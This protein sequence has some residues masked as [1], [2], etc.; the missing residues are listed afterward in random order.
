MISS[1]ELG[2]I[3]DRNDAD[4]VYH[5]L[6]N[7][8]ENWQECKRAADKAYDK[9]MNHFTWDIIIDQVRNLKL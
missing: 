4:T 7:C 6:K 1:K 5:A 3:I 2:M 9:L 8:L